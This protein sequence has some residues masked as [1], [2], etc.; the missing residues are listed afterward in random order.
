M[1]FLSLNVRGLGGDE[2]IRWFK[3]MKSKFGI[4][5][6]A[7]QESKCRNLDENFV[8]KVWGGKDV[9]SVWVDSSG[10]S[11]GLISMWD[12]NVFD[13]SDSIKD[14]N[15]IISRG[16]IKGSGRRINIANIYAPQDVQAKRL[17]W[18]RLLE[19]IDNSAGLWILIGDFNAVRSP[20]ERLKTRFNSLC[21][22]NFNSFIFDAGLMEYEMRDRKFTRWADK[23]RKG[24]KIDRLLVCPDFFGLWPSAC[25]RALPRYLSDHSPI[26]LITKELILGRNL[27]ESLT[28]GLAG[29][30]SIRRLERQR[31]HL[32]LKARRIWLYL[33]N[34]KSLGPVS[35][36]GETR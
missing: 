7:F 32:F 25:F 18:D 29:K 2:K 6:V 16:K 3:G 11:G 15:F 14:R 24:S 10:L 36:F 21:A 26:I 4:N 27:L 28:R 5:F 22:G 23:G 9:G 34:S 31:S 19:I 20:D 33:R 35:R 13:H 8:S 30:V 12:K 17:L 1:N